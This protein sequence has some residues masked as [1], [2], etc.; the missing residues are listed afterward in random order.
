MITLAMMRMRRVCDGQFPAIIFSFSFVPSEYELLNAHHV[1]CSLETTQKIQ[2][3]QK[4]IA[5]KMTRSH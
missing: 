3:V 1:M 4:L 5:V 2:V